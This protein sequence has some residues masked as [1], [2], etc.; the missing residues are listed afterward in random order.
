MAEGPYQLF[1]ACAPGL[2][3]LLAEELTALGTA[4]HASAGG[5]T[6]RVSLAQLYRVLLGCGLGL[7]VLLRLGT[8][9]AA[10][11][12]KLEH[13]LGEL[14]WARFLPAQPSVHVRATAS[15]SKLYHTGAIAERIMRVLER[16]LGAVAASSDD[17]LHVHARIE[18]DLCTI[19]LD[20]CGEPLHK[21]G[22]RK[23]TGKAPLREDL[24]RALLVL[25]GHHAGEALVD[26]LCGAGTFPIEGALY[27]SRTPPNVGR[28]FAVE[29]LPFHEATTLAEER[30]ALCARHVE[31]SATHQGSDR[32]QG[33]IGAAQ[34]NAER[35]SMQQHTSFRA[36]ALSAVELPRAPGLIIAN[37]PYGVRMGDVRK[38]TDLYASLG[39]LRRRVD[40]YR[41]AL[42]TAHPSLAMATGVALESALMTDLGGLKVCLYV[43][44]APAPVT[45]RPR[46]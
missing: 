7:K 28:A 15:K 29:R 37:P 2:E 23:E 4:P 27:A 24:A 40:G 18:R 22:Y 41:L 12:A 16:E 38:L 36:C 9:H 35:A 14:A 6:V 26:P 30:R 8:F 31:L 20:L 21:R 17:A 11:F 33:V 42:V 45:G 10:H 1:V 5:V 44:R 19:S 13:A 46:H 43:E 34:R 3:P 32:D 25:A 39:A